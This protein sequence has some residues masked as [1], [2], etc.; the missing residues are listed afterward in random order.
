MIDG[1]MMKRDAN[2]HEGLLCRIIP[3]TWRVGSSIILATRLL[4]FYRMFAVI[5]FSPAAYDN[6]ITA[7]AVPAAEIHWSWS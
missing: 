4:I 6:P 3:T 2:R 7:Q 5:G 1:L